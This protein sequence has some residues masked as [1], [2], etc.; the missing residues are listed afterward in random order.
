M[1]TTKNQTYVARDRMDIWTFC[2]IKSHGA[3]EIEDS[4]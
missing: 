4:R 2:E 1:T 3:D